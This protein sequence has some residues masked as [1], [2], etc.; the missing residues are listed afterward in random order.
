VRTRRIFRSFLGRRKADEKSELS[1]S[2]IHQAVLRAAE[3]AGA[4]SLSGSHLDIGSGSGELLRL[5]R[6]RYSLQS[7]ACDYTDQL[8][9]LP[10]QEVHLV[11]LD[12]EPLPFRDGEFALV[13]CAET[14]EHLENFRALL[15]EAFRVLRPG[16]IFVLSTPNIL[17]LRSRFRF[18]SSGFHNLF[19]PLKLDQSQRSF[20]RGHITPVNWFYLGH[21]LLMTGFRDVKVTTDKYQRRSFPAYALLRAPI[22]LSNAIVYRRDQ[23]K[24][25]T[26]DEQNAWLVR[27]MNSRDLLLGRSLIVSAVK[28]S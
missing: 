1:T 24:Y 4:P 27:L 14:I 15:R 23:R 26:V 20:A 19:G 9:E 13:T 12:R 2:N 3:A 10:G 11:E 8:M 6:E 7:V 16:G 25:R 21:A 22:F 17:N 28:P 5:V 18:F